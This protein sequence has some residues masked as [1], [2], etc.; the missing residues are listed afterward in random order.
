MYAIHLP[1]VIPPAGSAGGPPPLGQYRQFGGMPFQFDYRVM[2]LELSRHPE[3]I[4]AAMAEMQ[5]Q[6]Q[7][8]RPPT[9]H[10]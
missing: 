1:D 4:P 9:S 8:Q 10:K 5:K 7:Q 2:F 3:R 6:F